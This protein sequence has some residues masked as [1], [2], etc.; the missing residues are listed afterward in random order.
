MLKYVVKRFFISLLTLFILATVVFFLLHSLPGDPIS[1]NNGILPKELMNKLRAHYGLDQPVWKQYIQYFANM[2]RGELGYSLKHANRT[3]ASVIRESFHVSASLGLR[4]LAL[5]YPIGVLLGVIAAR[6]RGKPADYICIIIGILAISVPSFILARI[7][8]WIF[9]VKLGWLPVAQWKGF[10]Y[11]ILPVFCMAFGMMNGRSM[12]AYMLE[13]VSQDYIKTAKAKGVP[14]R[15]R[16]WR[17]M[18]RNA[19]LPMVTGLGPL[20]AGALT[21]TFVIETIFSI[22][23][24]GKQYVDAVKGLDYTLAMGLTTFFAAFLIFANFMVDLAYGLVD[25]RVRIE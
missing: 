4:G 6:R 5:G 10:K 15:R 17:H 24:L 25:P 22:P 16:V 13:V 8:Q 3:V 7:L 18:F 20:V 19:M 12:R 9:S 11:T 2:F 14:E 23:G 1:S 21:G